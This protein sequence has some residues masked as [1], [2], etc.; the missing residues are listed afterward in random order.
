MDKQVFSLNNLLH[1][2]IKLLGPLKPDLLITDVDVYKIILPWPECTQD[3]EIQLWKTTDL[4]P[5][6]YQT[7]P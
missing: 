4:H 1:I 6:L 3:Q 2:A 5:L 7:N